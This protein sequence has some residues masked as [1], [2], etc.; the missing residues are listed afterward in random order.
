MKFI[1]PLALIAA[2]FATP[3]LAQDGPQVFSL[4]AGCTPYLTVQMSA[5]NVDHHF[6]CEGDPEG[7]QRNIS[8][9]EQG[10][11]Y[12]GSIDFETQ[13]MHSFHPLNGH[14]EQLES[15]P[16]DRANFSELVSTG[17]DTYD[18]KT[19]S[20]EIGVTRYVG[21]DT[22]TGREVEI[23]GVTL[24]ETTYNITAYDGQGTFLW[25]TEGKEYISRDWRMFLSGSGNVTTPT[26]E[27]EDNNN[28]VEF[29]FPNEPGF[30]SANPKFGCGLMM[31]S[32]PM[33]Q[34]EEIPDDN[35]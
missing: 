14:S 13:W 7:E 35:I 33:T 10:M 26:E 12:M 27:Y 4:P 6:T 25:S 31:S 15:N 1:I 17:V 28:P 23:D 30:M 34:S 16:V 11:T 20:D 18:F 2:P 19:L 29:I 5:C 8:L 22:L 3:T 9:D 21:A 32:A 24:S